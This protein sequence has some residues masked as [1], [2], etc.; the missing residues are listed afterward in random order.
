MSYEI[1]FAIAVLGIAGLHL[2]TGLVNFL[3]R[4]KR[5]G[6]PAKGRQN[7]RS[8]W[9]VFFDRANLYGKAQVSE[10][11]NESA[12]EPVQTHDETNRPQEIYA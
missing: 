4:F 1:I 12:G 2:L 8:D 9:Y 7:I 5:A 6:I 11:I 10:G 3:A